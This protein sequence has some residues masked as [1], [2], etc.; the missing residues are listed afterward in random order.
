MPMLPGCYAKEVD[1]CILKKHFHTGYGSPDDWEWTEIRSS[2]LGVL[3][4]FHLQSRL[5]KWQRKLQGSLISEV[6]L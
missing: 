2:P 6:A 1:S 4:V 3:V 5:W